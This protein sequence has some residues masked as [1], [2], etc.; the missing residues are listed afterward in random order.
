MP[1]PKIVL[2][3]PTASGK[4]TLV[5][6]ISGILIGTRTTC[7]FEWN[8]CRSDTDTWSAEVSVGYHFRTLFDSKRLLVHGAT[9]LTEDGPCSTPVQLLR[10]LGRAQIIAFS[11]FQDPVAILSMDDEAVSRNYS[12]ILLSSLP[13]KGVIYVDLMVPGFTSRGITIVDLPGK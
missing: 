3:G 9:S 5:A 1:H 13:S 6:S 4:S 12:E 7:P 2:V 10:L 8:I 11:P